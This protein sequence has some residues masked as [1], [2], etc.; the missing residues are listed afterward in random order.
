M[1]LV[2]AFPAQLAWVVMALLSKATGGYR[3]IGIFP[4]LYRLYGRLRLPIFRAW[5]CRFELDE[6]ACGPGKAAADTVW[7]QAIAAESATATGGHAGALLL[8]MQKFYEL[9]NRDKLWARA[10][11]FGLNLTVLRVAL[12]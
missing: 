6:F 12:V 9:F 7:R 10:K 5:E 1:E 11:Q 3:P 8:D 4:M 2:G